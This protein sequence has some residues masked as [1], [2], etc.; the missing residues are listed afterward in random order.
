MDQERANEVAL[1]DEQL[2]E[3]EINIYG[4]SEP[5][6]PNP[7]P[8]ASP[9]KLV[10]QTSEAISPLKKIDSSPNSGSDCLMK[11]KKEIIGCINN[12]VN[13]FNLN[14]KLIKD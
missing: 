3:E 7:P 12:L 4:K 13:Q 2:N 11:R 9:E 14:N 5:E 10:T 6:S 8:E 1:L